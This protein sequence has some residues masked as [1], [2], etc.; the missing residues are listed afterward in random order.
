MEAQ[1]AEAEK[2]PVALA[3]APVVEVSCIA[4]EPAGGS[5]GAEGG[6][7]VGVPVPVVKVKEEQIK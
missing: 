2:E 4:G 1:G 3:A 6:A 5:T 7:L